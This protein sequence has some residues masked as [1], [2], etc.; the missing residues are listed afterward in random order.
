VSGLADLVTDDRVRRSRYF[1]AVVELVR[2]GDELAEQVLVQMLVPGL[3]CMTNQLAVLL[4]GVDRHDLAS[5]VVSAAWAQANA[6]SIGRSSA[7]TAGCILRNVRRDTIRWHR[8]LRPQP[9]GLE[10]VLALR[11]G[12]SDEELMVERPAA[13][14]TAAGQ[15]NG[16]DAMFEQCE[17][18]LDLAA[19]VRAGAI[20]GRLAKLVWQVVAEDRQFKQA[21]SDV[22]LSEP[23]AYQLRARTISALRTHLDAA[24]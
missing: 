12:R 24:A 7:R 10:G 4:P 11:H 9:N 2:A 5:D 21:A 18:R 22:G 20:D 1:G 8:S 19:A 16:V 15:G 6:L 14:H 13:K 17:I 3:I 23:W